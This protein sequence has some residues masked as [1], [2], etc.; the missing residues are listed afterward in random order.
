M[1]DVLV[2]MRRELRSYYLSPAG[3]VV[4]ALIVGVSLFL[5]ASAIQQGAPASTHAFFS[6]L[7]VVLLFF[8]P[9]VT[10][11]LWAEE[12][13][14]GTIELLM[15]FPV[16]V[17]QLIAGKFLAAMVFLAS[18]L[19]L[20]CVLPILI[21]LYGELDWGPVLGAYAGALLM[22]GAYVAVGMFFSSLTRDQIVAGIL[23]LFVLLG[24]FLLGWPGFLLVLE[25]AGFS[26]LVVGVL[27]GL[28]PY[29]YFSSI[30]RGV[31]DTRDLVYYA[32]FCGFFLHA[33]AMVLDARRLR[34]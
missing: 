20:T 1:R 8:L 29:Q 4:G 6:W 24:L 30:A 31:L 18:L 9:F 15:T 32:V 27:G 11:R 10:M 22:A 3:Y 17:S 7:P 28:S 33:N 19:A 16:R 34:G 23:A 13:K 21:D 12:R 26:D 5:G 14:L 2:V 25:R